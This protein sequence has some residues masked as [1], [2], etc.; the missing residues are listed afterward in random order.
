MN[1]DLNIY[2]GRTIEGSNEAKSRS[3]WVEMFDMI[4]LA[5]SNLQQ[6]NKDLKRQVTE[7]NSKLNK[8]SFHERKE[9][10]TERN[11]KKVEAKPKMEPEM[12]KKI[13]DK[14][15]KIEE[16]ICQWIDDEAKSLKDYLE[17]DICSIRSEVDNKNLEMNKKVES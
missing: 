3:T 2:D 7:L 5:I 14:I 8:I 11:L 13:E 17:K 4:D 1:E 6:Q 16:N 9:E 10:K 12:G 15:Q